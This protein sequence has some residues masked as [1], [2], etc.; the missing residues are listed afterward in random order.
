VD[1]IPLLSED[2]INNTFLYYNIELKRM[3]KAV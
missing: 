1:T 3:K 2:A